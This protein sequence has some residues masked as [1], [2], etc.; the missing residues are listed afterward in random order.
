MTIA[1]ARQSLN[2]AASGGGTAGGAGTA[3]SALA[4]TG[5]APQWAPPSQRPM[6][7][8]QAGTYHLAADAGLAA[9]AAAGV[10]FYQQDIR[11]VEVCRVPHKLPSGKTTMTPAARVVPAA[12]LARTLTQCV[13]WR[14]WTGKGLRVTTEP[15]KDVVA[16]ILSVAG[17]WPFPPLR[18]VVSTQTMRSDGSLLTEPGYDQ[19]TGLVLFDPPVMPPIPDHPDRDDALAALELLDALLTEFPFVADHGGSR[20]SALSLLLTAVQRG[21]MPVAP[22]YV[23]VKPQPGTGGSYLADIAGAI[24]LGDVPPSWRGRSERRR[25]TSG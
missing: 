22:M 9:M 19:A 12:S 3:A 14:R 13:D 1:T 11:L 2:A 16:Q 8:I 21:M 18:G 20:A 7:E 4:G 5:N 23:T 25:T 17:Q 24:A 15:P 6:I 10:P